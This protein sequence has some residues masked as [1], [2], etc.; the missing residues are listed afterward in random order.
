M[1]GV[2]PMD[3]VR[4]VAERLWAHLKGSYGAKVL[5]LI[6][7]GSHARGSA[8]PE[9]DVDVLVVVD[10]ALDPW[11]VRRSMDGVLMDI[12]LEKKLFGFRPRGT[13]ELLRR[14]QVAVHGSGPARRNPSMKEVWDLTAKAERFL[15]S[16]KHLLALGDYDSCA[17]RCYYAAFFM[18]ESA[19]M[20]NG[21]EPSSDRGVIRLFGQHFIL[22]GIF[23]PE[24]GRILRRAYDVCLAGDY[25]VGLSVSRE[26]AENLL[27]ATRRF[28]FEERA[29]LGGENQ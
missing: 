27:D 22:T 14:I 4:K 13:E 25:G 2:K 18:A 9:S 16:A 12:L 11:E 8:T 21:V 1:A 20:Q 3:K 28:V 10:D 29:Y 15:G 26:E 17:S 19:L 23:P 7:Y 5:H 6:L 24:L